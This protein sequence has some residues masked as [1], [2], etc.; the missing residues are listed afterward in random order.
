MASHIGR[1]KFL[2]TLG[3]AAVW[4]FAAR[5]QQRRRIGV[6]MPFNPG[7]RRVVFEQSL[8][9]LGWALGQNVHIEY[10]LTGSAVE[11]I[12]RHAAELV[13]L[14]PDAIVTAGA[15]APG[16]LLQATRTVPI[17][18]VNVPDPVGAGY[19]QSLARPGGNATGFTNFEYSMSGKWVE[20]LKQISHLA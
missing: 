13:A 2:A 14:A 8:H 9:Q 15:L 19:V 12:S 4:P 11:S 5:A 20:L 7:D 17:V 16:L 3:G 18:M 1:R 10:R 6:L